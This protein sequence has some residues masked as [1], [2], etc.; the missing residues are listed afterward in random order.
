MLLGNGSSDKA[1]CLIN[2]LLPELVYEIVRDWNKIVWISRAEQY[3]NTV[4]GIDYQQ[5]VA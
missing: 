4:I 1:P 5:Q 3:L 2:H